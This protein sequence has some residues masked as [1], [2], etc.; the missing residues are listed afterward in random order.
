MALP[1][2]AQKRVELILRMMADN[3][4]TAAD[5]IK[6][7]DLEK[8]RNWLQCAANSLTPLAEAIDMLLPG[9]NDEE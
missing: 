6:A 5:A 1:M 8:M 9:E 3:Y 4:T 7:G 2:D